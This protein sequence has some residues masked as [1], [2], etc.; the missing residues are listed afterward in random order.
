MNFKLSQNCRRVKLATLR[1]RG[2]ESCGRFT[3]IMTPSKKPGNA[4]L[5]YTILDQLIIVCST[6]LQ[7]SEAFIDGFTSGQEL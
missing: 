1:E 3:I 2:L 7:N 4:K 5:F 6:T